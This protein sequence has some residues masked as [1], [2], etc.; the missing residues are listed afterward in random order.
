MKEPVSEH[1]VCPHCG[2][3]ASVTI[4]SSHMLWISDALWRCPY[5]N[6][7]NRTDELLDE[8]KR[9]SNTWVVKRK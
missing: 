2:E 1:K 5:C 3:M 6:E 9:K 8:S 4:T 7:L